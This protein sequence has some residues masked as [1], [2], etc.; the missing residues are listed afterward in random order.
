MTTKRLY[1]DEMSWEDALAEIYRGR[2]TDFCEV[3]VDA[4][5]RAVAKRRIGRL[6]T[7]RELVA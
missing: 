1:R 3:C 5:E 4:L 2:G 7:V 6:T